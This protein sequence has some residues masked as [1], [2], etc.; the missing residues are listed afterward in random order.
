MNVVELINKLQNTLNKLINKNDLSVETTELLNELLETLKVIEN[1]KDKKID[2]FDLD[3]FH[4]LINEI[5]SYLAELEEK[6][7]KIYRNGALSW[8]NRRLHEKILCEDCKEKEIEKLTDK[9]ET[10][11]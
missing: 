3:K 5:E 11:K 8:I 1:C 9:W 2:G 7:G 4:R 6:R 10:K